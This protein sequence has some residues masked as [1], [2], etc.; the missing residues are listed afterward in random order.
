MRGSTPWFL[1][2]GRGQ[3]QGEQRLRCDEQHHAEQQGH[4][5]LTRGPR[6]CKEGR[7]RDRHCALGHGIPPWSYPRLYDRGAE[8]EGPGDAVTSGPF[9]VESAAGLTRCSST[10]AIAT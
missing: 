1:S 7:G 10:A 9:A 8:I 5:G 4:H 6:D 2:S 3:E